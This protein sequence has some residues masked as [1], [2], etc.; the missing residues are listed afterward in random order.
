MPLEAC[1]SLSCGQARVARQ[2]CSTRS[3]RDP[4]P[5]SQPSALSSPGVMF[6]PTGSKL[7][8]QHCIC[9]SHHRMNGEQQF[10][11]WERSGIAHPLG[12]NMG[13]WPHP[14]EGVGGSGLSFLE[15]VCPHNILGRA[16]ITKRKEGA[17]P[18]PHHFHLS[19]LLNVSDTKFSSAWVSFL[20]HCLAGHLPILYAS[21]DGVL[22]GSGC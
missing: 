4:G 14:A 3:C 18:P 22:V 6:L 5:F 2:L 19:L 20:A 12:E 17:L 7:T 21:L 9:S 11:L 13:M 8:L 1:F 15:A 16:F 10:L